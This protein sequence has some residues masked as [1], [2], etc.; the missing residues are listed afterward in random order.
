MLDEAAAVVQ[1]GRPVRHFARLPRWLTYVAAVGAVALMALDPRPDPLGPV[2]SEC[3]MSTSTS[4]ARPGHAGPADRAR[5][6]DIDETP[7]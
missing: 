4:T 5:F 6:V 2:A 7:A 1:T 3:S